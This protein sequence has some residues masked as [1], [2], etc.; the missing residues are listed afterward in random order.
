MRYGYK[1]DWFGPDSFTHLDTWVFWVHASSAT[2]FEES[3]SNIAVRL[4]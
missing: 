1:S 3:Y 2:R 4:N